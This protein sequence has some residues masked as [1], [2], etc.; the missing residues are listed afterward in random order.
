[1]TVHRPDLETLDRAL[2]SLRRFLT[3][4]PVLDDRG[5]RVELSTLLVLD[6]LPLEGESIREV[7]ARLDVTHSTAS[8][9]VT[10]AEEAGMTTRRRSRADSR[11]TLVVPTSAGLD[12]AARATAFRLDRIASMVG[13]WAPADLHRFAEDLQR[14]ARSYRAQELP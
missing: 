3:A 14:F 1:M 8:R 5:Q 6:G 4:P 12:L 13:D 9:L 10:R 11:E 7:A 2:V